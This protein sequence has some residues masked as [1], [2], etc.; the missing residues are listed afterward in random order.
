MNQDAVA[1]AS[2]MAQ[3]ITHSGKAALCG[4]YSHTGS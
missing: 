4:M 2:R 1:N 3:A